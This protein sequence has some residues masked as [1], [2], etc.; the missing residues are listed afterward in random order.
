MLYPSVKGN[1]FSEDLLPSPWASG[2]FDYG[3]TTSDSRL[4][5]ATP[6]STRVL[7]DDHTALNAAPPDGCGLSITGSVVADTDLNLTYPLNQVRAQAVL[8]SDSPASVEIRLTENMSAN[9]GGVP[10]TGGFDHYEAQINGG[11]WAAIGTLLTDIGGG[12][13]HW[14]PA[15]ATESLKIRGENAADVHS[16]YVVMNYQDGS[17][18][19][20][21][22]AFARRRGRR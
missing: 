17:L 13:F 19:G 2:K 8:F 4:N 1:G 14:F 3:H 18:N 5:N 22:P 6:Q 16:N 21:A 15:A 7:Y 9:T 10:D 12:V 20:S 11:A